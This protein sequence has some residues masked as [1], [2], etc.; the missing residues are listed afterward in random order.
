MVG[1]DDAPHARVLPILQAIRPSV[2]HVGRI[3]T[4]ALKRE[5]VVSGA[6]LDRKPS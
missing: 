6:C 3:G 2:F 4:G 5:S 1:P